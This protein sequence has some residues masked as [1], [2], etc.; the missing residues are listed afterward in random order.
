M[1]K[2][3]YETQKRDILQQTNMYL[4]RYQELPTQPHNIASTNVSGTFLIESENVE[5]GHFAYRL[6]NG[7]NVFNVGGFER[8]EDLYDCFDGGGPT[9]AD[10]YG[11]NGFAL[12]SENCYISCHVPNC[13]NIYYSYYL[14]SCSY[15]L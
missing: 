14:E 5:N 12:G 6:K 10:I 9:S 13:N 4:Q 3:E 11:V 2:E 1:T 7:R 15:C 8:N